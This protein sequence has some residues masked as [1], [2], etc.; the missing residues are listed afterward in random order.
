MVAIST[1]ELYRVRAG[2][3]WALIALD[4]NTGLIAIES[5]FGSFNY[6][7]PPRHRSQPLAEFVTCLDF[8]YFMSKTRG[9]SAKEFDL[10]ETI[11]A[12]RRWV[13]DERRATN[14]TKEHARDA[15]DALDDI[16]EEGPRTAE[17][18]GTLINEDRERLRDALGDDWWDGMRQ[19]YTAECVAFWDTI[20]PAFII[21]AW[22]RDGLESPMMGL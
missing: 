1:A 11:K 17:H 22:C 2:F 13:I 12:F 15:W 19:R 6:V 4:D 20:W 10:D 9:L 5:S 7:W 18:C 8:G 3:E 16:H 14:I 21:Q